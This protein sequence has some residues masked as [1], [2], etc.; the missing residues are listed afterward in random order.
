MR[1]DHREISLM[2]KSPSLKPYFEEA[3]VESYRNGRDLAMGETE[4]PLSTFQSQC[5]YDKADVLDMDFCP[6]IPS[7]FGDS[8]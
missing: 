8:D 7:D 2:K 1:R 5:P 3:L 4:R 6:G